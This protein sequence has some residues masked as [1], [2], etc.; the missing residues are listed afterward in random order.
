MF[1]KF[2]YFLF[3]LKWFIADPA[4]CQVK[5]YQ[6]TVDMRVSF[7]PSSTNING[8]PSIYY[9]LHL[10]NFAKDT[11]ELESPTVLNP[12]DTSTIFRWQGFIRHQKILQRSDIHLDIT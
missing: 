3:F 4:T 10:T 5:S 1:K 9:E 11:L 2:I 7:I 12:V 8:K 6:T